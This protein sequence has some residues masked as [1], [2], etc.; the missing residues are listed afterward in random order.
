MI[1]QTKPTTGNPEY[2]LDI[3]DGFGL[4]VGGLYELIISPLTGGSITNSTKVSIGE[5]WGTITSTWASEPETWLAASQLFN[6]S[7]RVSSSMT[8][9]SKP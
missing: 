8:N 9:V 6:N 3:G 4:L 1:N 5:T 7:S 2:N